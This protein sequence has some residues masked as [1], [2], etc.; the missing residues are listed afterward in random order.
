MRTNALVAI[1]MAAALSACA[2]GY[3]SATNPILGLTG[4]YWDQPGPGSLIKVGFSGNGFIK[5][6][7]VATYLLYRCAEVAQREG[8]SHFVFYTSL[9][10]AIADKRSSERVVNSLGGK[11]TTYAYIQVVPAGEPE[12]LSAEEVVSRLGPI[13]KSSQ[14]PGGAS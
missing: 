8:G 7:K 2:T 1:A 6:E 9:P 3:H 12:A 4:G 10:D 5:G 14:K 13:V 11:P